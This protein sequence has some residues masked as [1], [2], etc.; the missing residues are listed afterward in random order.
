MRLYSNLSD[1][2]LV[3]LLKSG[4][5]LAYTEIF[6][7]YTRV[8]LRHAF[9]LLSDHEE[10]HDVVQDVFLQLWQK[11]EDLSFKTSL[12]AYLYASVRNK[13]FNLLSHQKV[14]LRYAESISS[15]MVEG[16]NIIEDQIREKELALIIEKEVDALPPKMRE[17]FLL[18]KKDEL[19]YRE[20]SE[21]LNISSETAKQQVYKAM[22]ILKLKID[23]FLSIY[24]FL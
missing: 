24:P 1:V 5:Q 19:N 2:E 23:S 13:I 22:K 20:I 7:R 3:D 14:I 4:N 21:R 6:E 12:S 11:R 10:A 16:Y 15:F 9:R 18:N 17:V 8:L